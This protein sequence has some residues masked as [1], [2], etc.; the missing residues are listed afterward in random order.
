MRLAYTKLLK[1]KIAVSFETSVPF[2]LAAPPS[3][4]EPMKPETHKI[5]LGKG[6][7]DGVQGP[8]PPLFVGRALVE[9]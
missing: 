6:M 4:L 3:V 8:E 2:E 7:P 5:L 1:G 9:E